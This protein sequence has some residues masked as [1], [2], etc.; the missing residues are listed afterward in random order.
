[1]FDGGLKASATCGYRM[2]LFKKKSGGSFLGIDIGAAGVKIAELANAGGRAKLI[3][4]AFLDR[5]VEELQTNLLDKPAELAELLKKMMAKARVTTKKGVAA[6]PISTV[7]SSVVSVPAVQGKELQ[8]AIE[9]Q[10]RKLIP[11]P[12]ENLILDWKPVGE[13]A[14]GEHKSSLVLITGATKE[15]V[16]RYL[17][18]FK[19]AGIELLSLE[20]EAFALIRSLVGRDKGTVMLVDV[21]AVRTNLVVVESGIPVLARSID[22]GGLTFTKAIADRVGGPLA[23]A[24]QMKIDRA[25]G[26]A[27]PGFDVILETLKNEVKYV[28]NL[29][30]KKIEKAVLS[31]GAAQ[32]PEVAAIVGSALGVRA[33]LGDPWARV[34]YPVPLKLTLEAIGPRFS[35]AVGLAMRE[36]E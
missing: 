20:T 15:A 13:P 31:G 14:S 36:I 12:F 6:L 18:V 32:I 2:N 5:P 22:V 3:T 33:Y 19:A 25:V 30:A 1:M 35:V 29:Y 9:V 24:E 23:Q 27:P 21:G 10:A 8:A 26:A 4:Y 34:I 16:N 28:A 7:F 17:A 11:V